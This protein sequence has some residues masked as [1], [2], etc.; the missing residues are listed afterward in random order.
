MNVPEQYRLTTGPQATSRYDGNNGIFIIPLS[1]RSKAIAICSDGLGWEHVSVR[2]LCQGDSRTPTWAEM[3]KIKTLFWGP[4]DWVIQYHPAE[5]EYV[6]N[7]PHVL[8][9]WRPVGVQFPTP[10]SIMVG[11]K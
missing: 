6:N 8:H 10:P 5:S 2:I 3:C 4:E 7:H 9:L 11:I 1:N